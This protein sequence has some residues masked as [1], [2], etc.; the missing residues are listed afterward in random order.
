MHHYLSG[1]T[2]ASLSHD[3]CHQFK[4][5]L[6]RCCEDAFYT[7]LALQT[8]LASEDLAGLGIPVDLAVHYV[9]SSWLTRLARGLY[10]HPT[11]PRRST[12]ACGC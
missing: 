11:I 5:W 2:G 9:R 6:A 3:S 10:C 12:P 1:Q 4:Q 7:R 8:P